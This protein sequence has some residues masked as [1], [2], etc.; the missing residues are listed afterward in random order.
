[1]KQSKSVKSL[2][3]PS[4]VKKLRSSFDSFKRCYQTTTER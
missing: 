3:R 2:I 1:M 4:E